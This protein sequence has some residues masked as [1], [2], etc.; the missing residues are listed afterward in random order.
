MELK[1]NPLEADNAELI[2]SIN[3]LELN[4]TEK[5]SLITE[6]ERLLQAV[7]NSYNLITIQYQNSKAGYPRL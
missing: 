1:L 2:S 5:V 7:Q 3:V 6:S 4:I